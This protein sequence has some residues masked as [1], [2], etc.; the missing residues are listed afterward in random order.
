MH[1]EADV[2]FVDAHS[3]RDRGSDNAYI[4]PQKC[5]LVFRALGRGEPG[6]VWLRADAI[7]IQIPGQRFGALAACT[8]N[9]AAVVR[10]AA[11]ER[12]QL[13]V[14]RRFRNHAI[15]QVRPVKTGDVATRI[16]A[17]SI[18]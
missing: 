10:P 9:D 7:L 12:Q 2:R 13:V 17:A 3:E 4:I 14:G 8:V 15:C 11:N 5:I 18:P 6:V 1:H 16:V